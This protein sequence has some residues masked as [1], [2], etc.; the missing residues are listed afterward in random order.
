MVVVSIVRM[1]LCVINV[2]K[3]KPFRIINAGPIPPTIWHL[4]FSGTLLSI[5]VAFVNNF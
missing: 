1:D 3:V 5:N 2:K 4:I